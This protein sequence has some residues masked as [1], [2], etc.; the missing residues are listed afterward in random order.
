MAFK[1]KIKTPFLDFEMED[2]YVFADGYSR[3]NVPDT[4]DI[5]KLIKEVSEKSI[6]IE[7]ERNKQ[8]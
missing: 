1:L 8:N 3:H 6:L 7:I 5:I 2:V 4:T